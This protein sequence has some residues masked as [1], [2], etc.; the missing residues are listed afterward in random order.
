MLSY[1][2]ENNHLYWLMRHRTYNIMRVF[3]NFMT[4]ELG[5]KFK[6]AVLAKD[7][8]YLFKVYLLTIISSF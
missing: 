6:Y 2:I 3:I 5:V 8:V 1:I 4:M 7:N